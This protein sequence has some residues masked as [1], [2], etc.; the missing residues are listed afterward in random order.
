MACVYLNSVGLYLDNELAPDEQDNLKAHIKD[1]P[2]CAAELSLLKRA[3]E[4]MR[5]NRVEG[6]PE[7]FLVNLRK[8]I[9][10]EQSN[11]F[12]GG[13]LA[14]DFG[15][16]SKRLVPVPAVIALVAALWLSQPQ[17]N[18]NLVDAYIFNADNNT[19]YNLVETKT[20]LPIV[21]ALIY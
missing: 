10:E 15:K 4:S 5:S 6:D 14:E 17:A 21:D 13:S 8:K 3:G 11:D 20:N 1:C 19:A 9:T 2:A 18:N 12:E 7:E 16:W